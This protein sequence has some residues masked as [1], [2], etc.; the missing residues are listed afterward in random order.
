[1]VVITRMTKEA[2]VVVPSVYPLKSD[3]KRPE[4]NVKNIIDMTKKAD[5]PAVQPQQELQIQP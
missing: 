4:Q 3:H 1:M 2:K 5:T